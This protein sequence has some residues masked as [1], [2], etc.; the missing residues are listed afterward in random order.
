MTY[1]AY[2]LVGVLAEYLGMGRVLA[3]LLL[4][5]VL[6]R[7]PW[8]SNRK[9]RVVGLLPKPV[10]RPFIVG[11]FALC[12]AH[13]LVRGEIV[14]ALFTGFTAVFILGMPWLRRAVVDR[15]MSSFSAFTGRN[16]FKRERN[17]SLVIDGEFRERKD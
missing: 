4:G 11:M 10:R 17:D 9:L 13:F 7:F 15:A 1:S 5:A 12:A 2:L 14:P 8:V 6:A 3:G 16:P